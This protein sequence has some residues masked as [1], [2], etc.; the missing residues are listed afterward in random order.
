MKKVTNI[1]RTTQVLYDKGKQIMLEPGKS[2]LMV[3]PPKESYTFKVEEVEQV[4][5]P[6]IKLKGGK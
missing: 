4:E 3:N 1:D 5:K 6:K 2:V